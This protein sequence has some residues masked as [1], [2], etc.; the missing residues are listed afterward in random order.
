LD[1]SVVIFQQFWSFVILFYFVILNYFA[2]V[3][4]VSVL[5]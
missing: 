3:H 5:A 1:I 2:S 4:R